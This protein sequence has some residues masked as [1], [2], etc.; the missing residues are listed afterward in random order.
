MGDKAPWHNPLPAWI[1]NLE[2]PKLRPYQTAI[3]QAIANRCDAKPI[4]AHGSLGFAF[5]GYKKL[6]ESTG[7][8]ERTAIGHIKTLVSMGLLVKVEIGGGVNPRTGECTSNAY[9]IPARKAL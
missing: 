6:A 8:G 5:I 2:R 3:L 1:R 9:A 4:D 7:M